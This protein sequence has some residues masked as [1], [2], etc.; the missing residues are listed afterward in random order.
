MTGPII[1]FVAP[2][3]PGLKA[4]RVLHLLRRNGFLQAKVPEDVTWM[5]RERRSWRRLLSA[6]QSST[7]A[8]SPRSAR[9]ITTGESAI[10]IMP[11]IIRAWSTAPAATPARTEPDAGQTIGSRECRLLVSAFTDERDVIRA[12]QQSDLD[13]LTIHSYIEPLAKASA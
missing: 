3:R 7:W 6:W 9:V 2:Y 1:P 10:G 8:S 11:F 12:Q 13:R 4:S 5:P